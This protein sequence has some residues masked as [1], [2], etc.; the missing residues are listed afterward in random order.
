ML[1]IVAAFAAA[2]VVLAT[3]ALAVDRN[4]S[5]AA[6]PHNHAA[7][8]QQANRAEELRVTL[9]RLLGEHALLA[10]AA[11]RKGY[12]G[13]RSFAATAASLDR[14]SVDL[15][16]VIGTAYGRNARN[17]FLNGKFMWRAHI[18]F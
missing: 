7:L 13:N 3:A 9:D 15:A 17:Q 5:P 18:K 10:I 11:T 12:D 16:N 14:N 1:G 2:A 8:A 6:A 4:S